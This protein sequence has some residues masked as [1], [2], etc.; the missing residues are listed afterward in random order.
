MPDPDTQRLD[1]IR[2][3]T[4]SAR[5]TWF[6]YLGTIAFVG[7]T[8]LDVE[9]ADFFSADTGTQL[10]LI[11]VE[12]PILSFFLAGSIL[13]TVIFCYLHVFLE[14]LWAELADGSPRADGLPLARA[15]QPWLVSDTALH[16]RA[17]LRGE[18]TPPIA[19]SP[20]G[21]LGVAVSAILAWVGG[22]AMLYGFWYRSQP[23]HIWWLTTI[24]AAS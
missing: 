2:A 15:I 3:L 8:L 11:G 5:A 21:T 1:R 12:V 24:I 7:V 16:L 18:A 17:Y 4:S 20:L 6:A 14:K 22:P 10:P 13:M 9:D 19:S 23:A